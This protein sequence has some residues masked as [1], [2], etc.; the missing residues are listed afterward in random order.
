MLYSALTSTKGLSASA[1]YVNLGSPVDYT[2]QPCAG[3]IAVSIR[4]GPSFAQK[5]EFARDAGCAALIVHNNQPG[6][7]NGTLGTPVDAQGRAWLPV[8]SLSLDEGLYLKDQIETRATTAKLFNVNGNLQLASGTS[9][10]S[11]HAAGVAALIVQRNPLWSPIQ[12]R[13]KLRSSA[14]DLGAAGWDPIFGYGRINA[15]RAVQ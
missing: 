14:N 12:V 15:K 4:G 9:M 10:A 7:F 13:E 5:A 2:L 1:I 8:V 6:N 11:P 3:K